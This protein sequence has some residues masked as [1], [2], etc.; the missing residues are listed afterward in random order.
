MKR[1]LKWSAMFL[2]IVII[3]ASV[4]VLF[5]V[6]PSKTSKKEQTHADPILAGVVN[7]AT[8]TTCYN[9]TLKIK[10]NNKTI[11]NKI[12]L[13]LSPN[14]AF[15]ITTDLSEFGVTNKINIVYVNNIAYISIDTSRFKFDASKV[16]N[17]I[18]FIKEIFKS[19][20]PTLNNTIE[21]QTATA[22]TSTS[23]KDVLEFLG[24][25]INNFDL[26]SIDVSALSSLLEYVDTN[27]TSLGYNIS[28]NVANTIS[29]SAN[30][31]KEFVL[32]D[33]ETQDFLIAGNTVA[34]SFVSGSTNKVK[35]SVPTEVFTDL[36]NSV[37][38]VKLV[39][40]QTQNTSFA[41]TINIRTKNES[42]YGM[43]YAQT[44]N[45]VFKGSLQIYLQNKPLIVQIEDNNWYLMYGTTQVFGSFKE[46]KTLLTQL[47]AGAENS[48]Q[49]GV[50]LTLNL[51]NSI[52]KIET[53]N[54][55]T[56]ILTN[57]N[58]SISF[59]TKNGEL[60]G[61]NI[62][63][64][65]AT[66]TLSFFNFTGSL[67]AVNKQIFKPCT[68]IQALTATSAKGNSFLTS[69]G[70]LFYSSNPSLS[71]SVE[72]N[73]ASFDGIATLNLGNGDLNYL[74]DG[75]LTIKMETIKTYNIKLYKSSRNVHVE[76]GTM[77]AYIS[78]HAYS[79]WTSAISNFLNV[80]FEAI[81]SA[82]KSSANLFT[83]ASNLTG[84]TPV[85]LNTISNAIN[86]TSVLNSAGIS[87]VSYT[88]AT[89]AVAKLAFNT[90]TDKLTFN[91][92]NFKLGSQ[93]ISVSATMLDEKQLTYSQSNTTTSINISNLAEL[94]NVTNTTLNNSNTLKISGPI[95][96]TLPVV[97]ELNLKIDMQ[98][99]N[100]SSGISG[101]AL[102]DNLPTGVYMNVP[103]VWKELTNKNIRHYVYIYF[104]GE[105][106]YFKR[107][108][109]SQT[110]TNLG[111]LLKP[112]YYYS[113]K[114]DVIESGYFTLADITTS[115]EKTISYIS[116]VL[117][118]NKLITGTINLI[119]KNKEIGKFDKDLD[120]LISKNG[121]IYSMN[122]HT[123][124]LDMKFITGNKD[125]SDLALQVKILNN[126]INTFGATLSIGNSIKF[127]ASYFKFYKTLESRKFKYSKNL[128][129]TIHIDSILS[130][131]M[132]KLES[133][134]IKK[135]LTEHF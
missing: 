10:I 114:E 33:F 38:I 135:T 63:H 17:D 58:Y 92:N 13:V 28:I 124:Y 89:G 85:S 71:L 84:K 133:G 21:N 88:T 55:A 102:I 53:T 79:S 24:I 122:T 77:N 76:F 72:M 37:D 62:A 9:G 25:N 105:T 61:I 20:A 73:N 34:I 83:F 8:N 56:N 6:L 43:F 116:P 91:L 78:S 127:N 52:A 99:K 82:L 12:Q 1:F 31:D 45:D 19:F 32:E 4:V 112:N 3:T 23:Q 74:L 96:I 128:T 22:T 7:S 30:F 131:E 75:K 39:S 119:G 66:L 117:G 68:T 129:Q 15:N 100:T 106:I 80:D 101:V 48:L 47:F 29:A 18:P 110:K 16:A 36:T 67:P 111:T 87:T 95:Y 97:G 60:S 118:V 120:K 50:D 42:I 57:K 54:N 49:G 26:N 123:V 69:V 40:K 81:I 46:I 130:T 109:S 113:A 115:T 14:V 35:V 65:S 2:L 107:C 70:K 59:I 104:K 134:T 64:Q 132:S 94:I 121:Y 125:F 11:N 108:V 93:K 27:E 44:Q 103:V 5:N 126:S 86:N 41:T 90:H 98:I 51:L